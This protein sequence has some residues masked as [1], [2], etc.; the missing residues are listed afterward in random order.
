MTRSVHILRHIA[1]EGPGHLADF[2]AARGHGMNLIAIDA[3]ASVPTTIE[4]MAALVL[5]GGPMSVNDPLPWIE[6]EQALIR[7]AIARNIPVLGICLGAQLIAGA[8]GGQ[9]GP[10]AVRE[11]GWHDVQRPATAPAHPWLADLPQ[12]FEAFH[13]HGETFTLPAGATLLLESEHCRH[14]AFAYGSALG[15]QFHLE[16]TAEMVPAW[17]DAYPADMAAPSSS[18][19]TRAQLCQ[20]LDQRVAALHHRADQL[21]S[22]WLD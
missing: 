5:L 3:G 17:A 14:Q 10:N 22:R 15:L 8:L 19:N 21:L 4:G 1:C 9:V 16:I 13:W 11:I 20:N 18:V 2:F 6:A 12:R 7:A